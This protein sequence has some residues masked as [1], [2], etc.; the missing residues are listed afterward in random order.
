M[1]SLNSA[2]SIAAQ[3]LSADTG[4]LQITDN[5]ISN[6]N[7]P[8]YTRELPVLQEVPPTQEGGQ[9]TGNG[10]VLE[11]Y[12]SVR[13]ELVQSRIEQET[14]AQSSANAQLSTLQQIQTA[15]TTSSQDIGTEISA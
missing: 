4:A 14:Q 1:A 2:L 6:A 5:N 9:Q 13:D 10:V 11:G 7:T 15:F 3:A 8:G 12:Q